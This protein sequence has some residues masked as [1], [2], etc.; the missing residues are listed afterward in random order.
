MLYPIMFVVNPFFNWI[1]MVYGIFTAG[2]RTWGGPRADAGTADVNTT[3]QAVV[4]KAEATGDDL[5]VVP[6]SFHPALEAQARFR[7]SVPVQPDNRLQGRFTAAEKLPGGWYKHVNDSGTHVGVRRRRDPTANHALPIQSRDSIDSVGSESSNTFSIYLPR[8]VESFMS[9]EQARLYHRSRASQRPP[10]GAFYE[11]G[12]PTTHTV[13][14]HRSQMNPHSQHV[15][16][17][18]AFTIHGSGGRDVEENLTTSSP[19]VDSPARH[20]PEDPGS[21]PS[22][23]QTMQQ[24]M[25]I[26]LD[27]ESEN[28]LAHRPDLEGSIT[29]AEGSSQSSTGA[30]N[31]MQRPDVGL[32]PQYGQRRRDRTS[33]GSW[34]AG[35]SPLSRKSFMR[36]SEGD[37]ELENR[38]QTAP[39][40]S[41]EASVSR[42]LSHRRDESIGSDENI[43][44]RGRRRRRLTK[45]RPASQG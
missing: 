21:N 35:R 13:G 41:T 39:G 32:P 3:V 1:Y 17:V 36:T 25:S 23:V 40:E 34:S 43:E 11:S 24:R 7:P 14:V 16:I 2:Q 29:L 28:R 45:S 19:D 44:P 12:A 8:R 20:L 6:E 30:G 37:V 5:N 27:D 26:A 42:D 18:T 33:R 31:S 9:P 10:G 22:M 15:P 38:P 4:E